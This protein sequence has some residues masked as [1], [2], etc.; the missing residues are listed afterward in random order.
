[1]SSLTSHRPSLVFLAITLL[2][3]LAAS[4]APTPLYHLYQQHLD[5]SAGMLTLIFGVYALSL[6][7]ALLTVGSLS[8]YLGRKPV[9]FAALILEMLA[10]LLCM[11]L[12]RRAAH[13]GL[14]CRWISR[15]GPWAVSIYRWRLL[16]CGR[17]PGRHQT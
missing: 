1:M 11:C 2:T 4:S 12:P 13:C 17:R 14:H 8:D 10:M 7:A 6:L 15:C 5:F 9:I 16:W 3:F